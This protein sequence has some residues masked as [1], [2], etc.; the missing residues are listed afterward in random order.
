MKLV[1]P[2]VFRPCEGKEGYTVV[3]PDVPGCFTVSGT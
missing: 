2:A 3:V 1:Y